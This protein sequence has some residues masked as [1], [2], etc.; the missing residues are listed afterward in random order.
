MFKFLSL[1]A[2]LAILL[3]VFAAASLGNNIQ[4]HNMEHPSTQEN[5]MN[6]R[7]TASESDNAYSIPLFLTVLAVIIL[8]AVLVFILRTVR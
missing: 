6:T 1:F 4:N 5:A 3:S 2:C 8:L 7:N